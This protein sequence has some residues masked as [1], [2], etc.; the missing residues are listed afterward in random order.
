MDCCPDGC[1]PSCPLASAA[2][3]PSW[4]SSLHG[5]G[6]ALSRTHTDEHSAYDRDGV[7]LVNKGVLTGRKLRRAHRIVGPSGRFPSRFWRRDYFMCVHARSRCMRYRYFNTSALSLPNNP[8]FCLTP[9]SCVISRPYA[10]ELLP[11]RSQWVS[12]ERAAVP[13][14]R[15]AR[16]GGRVAEEP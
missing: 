3:S 4:P 10:R 16:P 8:L 14:V 6:A 5:T 1:G 12:F 9:S 11:T 7:V 2:A 15:A 13:A